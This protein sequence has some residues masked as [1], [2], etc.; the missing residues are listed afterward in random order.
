[1]ES[2]AKSTPEFKTKKEAKMQENNNYINISIKEGA[3][4]NIKKQA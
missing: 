2:N 1:M 3:S 4:K